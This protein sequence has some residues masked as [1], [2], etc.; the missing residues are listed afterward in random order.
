[1]NA[2]RITRTSCGRRWPLDEPP[3]I[4]LELVLETQ[5]YPA[6]E[7]YALSCPEPEVANRLRH[8]RGARRRDRRPDL[9]SPG[10]D[11]R[12]GPEPLPLTP[13]SSP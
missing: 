10:P 12:P 13:E 9:A 6:C 3:S 2:P 8:R 5:P 7:A 4:Y 11:T 1:M